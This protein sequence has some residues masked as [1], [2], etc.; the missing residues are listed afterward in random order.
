[1]VCLVSGGFGLLELPGIHPWKRTPVKWRRQSRLFS[2]RC[3]TGP[4]APLHGIRRCAAKPRT[5]V[6]YKVVRI[7]CPDPRK[8]PDMQVPARERSLEVAQNRPLNPTVDRI[9]GIPTGYNVRGLRSTWTSDRVSG[10]RCRQTPGPGPLSGPGR[11]TAIEP[12][13]ERSDAPGPGLPAST[14]NRGERH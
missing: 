12:T 9:R 1:M 11:G 10:T 13:P 6:E 5:T 7:T 8:Q 14:G 2:P 4:S 3:I